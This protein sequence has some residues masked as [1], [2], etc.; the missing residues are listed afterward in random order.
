MIAKEIQA[1]GAFQAF[2]GA[3]FDECVDSYDGWCRMRQY[4]DCFP[5][6]RC[7]G[8]PLMFGTAVVSI[9]A[10]RRLLMLAASNIPEILVRGYGEHVK[11]LVVHAPGAPES[12]QQH[13]AIYCDLAGVIGAFAGVP[14]GCAFLSR[15]RTRLLEALSQL[16]ETAVL[17]MPNL[18]GILVARAGR[19][20]DDAPVLAHR[21]LSYCASV[22]CVSPASGQ[23]HPELALHIAPGCDEWLEVDAAEQPPTLPMVTSALDYTHQQPLPAA[24][25]HALQSCAEPPADGCSHSHP[26]DAPTHIRRFLHFAPARRFRHASG[27]TVE[28]DCC[29]IVMS[30]AAAPA[31]QTV[32]PALTPPADAQMRASPPM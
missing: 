32:P 6:S 3:M 16:V 18:R 31:G 5:E 15:S 19:Q 12:Q 29:R 25:L 23:L 26:A 20:S 21:R 2:L 30:V 28:Y 11:H 13:S 7:V 22:R 24:L 1:W 27:E 14:V 9:P 8:E 17:V 4:M 10:D